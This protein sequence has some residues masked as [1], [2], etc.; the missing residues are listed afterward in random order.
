MKSLV[1]ACAAFLLASCSEPAVETKAKAPEKPPAPLSGRQAFQQTYAQART[2]A[3]DSLPIRIR[4]YNLKEVP[5]ADGKSGAWDVTFASPS[6]DRAK[7]FTWSAVE[8]E[9]LHKGVFG[10]SE[11][12]WSPTSSKVFAVQAIK[13]DTPAAFETARTKSETY[14]KRPGDRPPVNFLLEASNRFPNPAWRIYW[15]ESAS[16]AEFTVFVDATTG[17]FLQKN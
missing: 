9:G 15:G 13:T 3:S 14:L 7:T 5:S 12:S 6:R 4:N 11:E 8:A 10:G 17:E 1:A 16:A 2:W